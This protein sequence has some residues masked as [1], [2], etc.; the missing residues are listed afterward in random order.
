MIIKDNYNVNYDVDTYQSM[1]HKFIFTQ[2]NAKKGINI[3]G[4][5]SS[6]AMFKEYKQLEY[7]NLVN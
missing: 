6:A 1:A 5:R 2:M 7:N 3:F 4:E